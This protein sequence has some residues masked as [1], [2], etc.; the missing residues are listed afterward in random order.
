MVA[1][2]DITRVVPGRTTLQMSGTGE[3]SSEYRLEMHVGVPLDATTQSV[4]GE[5][6]AQSEIRVWRSMKEP[7]KARR[8][9]LRKARSAPES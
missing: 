3:D 7:I 2:I 9:S 8:A 4:L 1:D 6:L 5:L